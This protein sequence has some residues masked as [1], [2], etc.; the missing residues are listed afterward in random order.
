LLTPKSLEARCWELLLMC[1][2]RRRKMRKTTASMTF[3]GSGTYLLTLPSPALDDDYELRLVL[4][5][6][7]HVSVGPELSPWGAPF[8]EAFLERAIEPFMIQHIIAN[9]TRHSRWLRALKELPHA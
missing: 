2:V 8:K 6:L 5:E 3:Q 7:S 9:P 4:H 1:K